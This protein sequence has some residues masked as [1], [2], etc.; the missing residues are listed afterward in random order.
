M[1]RLWQGE[2]DIQPESPEERVIW[3]CIVW[4]YG[5]YVLGALYVLAPVIGWTL[6]VKIARRDGLRGLP[7]AIWVWV[8]GMLGMQLVLMLAYADFNLGLGPMIKS[9]IGW[10]KGW[11][12]LPIFMVIGF[13]QVRLALL[14]RAAC[15]V[16]IQT[17]VVLPLAMAAWVVHL[18]G[19]LYVS[20]VSIV[21]G[22]GPEYF[23]V[24]LYGLSPGGGAPRWR[25]FAP[26]AP[27]IGLVMCVYFL[28][29]MNEPNRRLRWLGMGGM[30]AC[31]LGSGSRLGLLAL[32]VTLGLAWLLANLHQPRLYFVASPVAL[33]GGMLLEPITELI[34]QARSRFDGAR[35]DSSRVRAALGRI[36]MHRWEQDGTWF[37]H[38]TVERG[39]HLVEHMPIGS[40]HTWFGLLFVKGTVGALSLALPMLWSVVALCGRPAQSAEGATAL[41]ILALLFLYTFAENL[42]IL[43]YLYW[44]GLV[45]LGIAFRHASQPAPAPSSPPSRSEPPSETPHEPASGQR[46]HLEQ[47]R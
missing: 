43:A 30:V 19:H 36:A 26:W 28:L 47:P 12:L 6:L 39:P 29:A 24:E 35:A 46:I 31:I 8:V 16:G 45:A 38:G 21:G 37:G 33:L 23:A 41:R 34:A 40:H 3:H 17:L 11:A 5:Y 25:L 7:L 22:P 20:P 13:G 14:A 10:A 4:T 15:V 32:P 1:K 2:P 44:P 9:S 27:A 42:E 18:P